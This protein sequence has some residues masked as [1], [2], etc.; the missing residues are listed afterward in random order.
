VEAELA[1][2][3][4]LILPLGGCEPYGPFGGLGAAAACAGALAAALSSRLRIIHA[5]VL[6]YG[7]STPFR[8][9]AGSAGMKPRTLVNLLCETIR[10]WFFQGFKVVIIIDA[11]PEN[12]RAVA[13][14]VRRLKGSDPEGSVLHF[15]VQRDERVRA[16]IGSRVPGR[17]LLRTEY[18]VLSMAAFID[19]ELVRPAETSLREPLLPDPER[20]AVWHKRGADPQ[21]YRKLFPDASSSTIAGTYDAGFG[22]E[23]FGYI[24]HSLEA[25]A[26]PLLAAL[27]PNPGRAES[28]SP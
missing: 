28:N 25:A 5:P 9:F 27:R 1:R 13:E 21:Q 15:S 6:A 4:V 17:E 19:P 16:F 23:L 11:L 10:P 2:L 12:E 8:T 14:A 22:K 26:A 24:L 20:F 7:C 3:P 18:G